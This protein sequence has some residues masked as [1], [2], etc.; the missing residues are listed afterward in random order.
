MQTQ[1]ATADQTVAPSVTSLRDAASEMHAAG[2]CV[3]PARQDGTKRPDVASWLQYQTTRSTPAEHDQWFGDGRATGIGVVYGAVSGNVELIEFEGRAVAEGVFAEVKD[4]MDAS[5]LGE[6]WQAILTGWADESPS[7]GV[8]YRVRVTGAPVPVNTKLANRLAREDEYTPKERK[9]KDEN[10]NKDITRGLIETRGEGGFGVTA[11]SHGTVHPSGKPYVRISGGP[12]T[13]PN[14]TADVVAAIHNVLKMLDRVPKPEKTSVPVT[15]Q[16]ADDSLRPGDDYE[17]RTD[18]ADILEP[19]GWT[20]VYERGTRYWRRPGKGIGVS[21]TTGHARDRDRL[22]VFTTSTEFEAGKPYTKFGAY[23]LLHHGGD[24]KAAAAE[25]SRQGYG[26]TKVDAAQHAAGRERGTRVNVGSKADVTEWL[27][28]EMGRCALSSLFLRDG[29][30]VHT[31]RIGEDGYIPP[32]ESEAGR[33]IHPGPAQVQPVT[34]DGVK[35]L[36]EVRYDVGK[37]VEDKKTGEKSWVRTMFPKESVTSAVSAAQ[38]GEG[39]PNMRELYGITHTPAMRPDGTVLDAPGYDASTGL[40]YLPERGVQVPAVPDRPSDEQVK[41]AVEFL[42]RPVEQFPFVEESHRANWLGLMMTPALRSLLPPPYQLGIATATNPGSGKGF[43]MGMIRAVHGGVLR[44]DLPREGDELRKSITSAL[45]DTTAP[46]VQFD[47]LKGTVQSPVL[48]ALLTSRT[49]SDRLLGFNRNVD[50]V[51][52]RLWVATGNNVKIGGD[53]PRRCLFVAIDPG[54]ADPHL[55]TG[56]R[57]HPLRWVEENRG[58]YLASI[59]TVARGWVLAGSPT[60]VTRS[61]DF[62][63]WHGALRGMLRWAGVPGLFGGDSTDISAAS[64]DDAEWSEFLAELHREFAGKPFTSAQVV[65]RI[66]TSMSAT[67]IAPQFLPGDLAEK[68]GR[69]A[70]AGSL[71]K[72]L[73]KWLSNRDGRYADGWVCKG[74]K[75]G[76]KATTYTVLPPV[77]YVADPASETTEDPWGR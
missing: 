6:A 11:P 36:V 65:Q 3:V 74:R 28:E 51:N 21:A 34:Q 10:P 33:G 69:M 46:I 24:H 26:A 17:A 30:I 70:G 35:A 29:L 50:L 72:S 16:P 57:L 40:L 4:L 25:L 45:I 68:H 5:G 15:R 75:A 14:L 55:R 48:E 44:G 23:A 61:D 18:W 27:R 53:L 76:K 59:L 42:L 62:K 56:F 41:E 9:L 31:P 32:T 52:D 39:V 12:G 64:E 54:M 37:T 71:T 66:A 67:G 7:G 1:N 63:E 38:M 43:L 47:N 22:Y 2:L 8:H 13:I 73:G 77:D 19:D 20:L 58:A 49:H 60:D